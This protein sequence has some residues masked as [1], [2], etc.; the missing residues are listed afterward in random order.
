[1]S[2]NWLA[3]TY[4]PILDVVV[5]SPGDAPR[6]FCELV[7]VLGVQLHDQRILLRRPDLVLLDRR[8]HVIVVALTT[9]L[10][11]SPWH[12]LRDLGPAGTHAST[13]KE[14][15][16]IIN[17]RHLNKLCCTGCRPGTPPPD[18]HPTGQGRRRHASESFVR[19]SETQGG[20][21]TIQVDVKLLSA[22]NPAQSGVPFT[23]KRAIS[24]AAPNDH[25]WF[26]FRTYHYR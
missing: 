14:T 16:D 24:P 20:V 2:L 10:S 1:M 23:M 22:A 11:G 26:C 7:V 21:E 13:D 12:H 18:C 9:L 15:D 17:T 19:S 8:V 25:G 3:E 6:D 5:A 4:V